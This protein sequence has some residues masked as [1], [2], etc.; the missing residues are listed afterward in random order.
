MHKQ[1]LA[2]PFELIK[3]DN[4]KSSS[5]KDVDKLIEKSR[6]V[7]ESHTKRNSY[8]I[9]M[10]CKFILTSRSF[11][12]YDEVK[13]QQSY[14]CFLP[15]FEIVH[16]LEVGT[17]FYNLIFKYFNS[18]FG[19]KVSKEELTFPYRFIH[20]DNGSLKNILVIKLNIKPSIKPKLCSF[21]TLVRNYS[22]FDD[23][24]KRILDLMYKERH[25]TISN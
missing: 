10:Q 6:Y 4:Y 1:V 7:L 5:L 16:D 21:K 3:K 25:K 18:K 14:N 11:Y 22:L 19:A 23:V 9:P 2:T 8:W 17:N 20:N 15:T 12:C 13:T 24:S